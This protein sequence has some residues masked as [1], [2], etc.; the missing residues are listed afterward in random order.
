VA[1]SW[2]EDQA[3]KFLEVVT[4]K[5]REYNKDDGED[6]RHVAEQQMAAEANRDERIG[7]IFKYVIFLVIWI[8]NFCYDYLLMLNFINFLENFKILVLFSP[9]IW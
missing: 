5:K 2:N 1:P 8:L 6:I 4:V 7:S 3:Q 9:P